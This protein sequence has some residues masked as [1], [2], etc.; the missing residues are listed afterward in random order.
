[1]IKKDVRKIGY[2]L[3]AV[4]CLTSCAVKYASNDKAQ[5]L[6]SKNGPQIE[7][8]PPLTSANISNFYEL[9]NPAEERKIGV[10]PPRVT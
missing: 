6:L 1:M 8:P 3:I 5:Y 2:W 9:P 10:T 7:V 4:C